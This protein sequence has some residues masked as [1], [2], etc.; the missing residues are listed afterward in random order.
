[1]SALTLSSSR[2][3]PGAACI[4]LVILNVT[5]GGVRSLLYLLFNIDA[6]RRSTN[7]A[8]Q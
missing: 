5:E 6:K 3:E 8:T 7:A 4:Q 2:P 1:M